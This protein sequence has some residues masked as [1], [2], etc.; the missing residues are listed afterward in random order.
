MTNIFLKTNKPVLGGCKA[1]WLAF[2]RIFPR[3][4][5]Q[6]FPEVTIVDDA[7]K[8][9]SGQCHENVDRTHLVL[10]IG[11]LVLRK[12]LTQMIQPLLPKAKCSPVGHKRMKEA[13]ISGS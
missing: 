12:N 4:D 10:D 5:S 3:F 13:K 6:H 1:E 2:G 11:D 7:A 9:N 8:R